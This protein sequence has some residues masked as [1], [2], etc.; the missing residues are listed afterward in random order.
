MERF[1]ADPN[2]I[3]SVNGKIGGQVEQFP[4]GAFYWVLEP[5]LLNE[6]RPSWEFEYR[7]QTSVFDAKVVAHISGRNRNL[8]G[9]EVDGKKPGKMLGS[10]DY[11]GCSVLRNP[12]K[13]TLITL[14]GV[15]S[16]PAA[17]QKRW[18]GIVKENKATFKEVF[19]NQPLNHP[20]LLHTCVQRELMTSYH[21]KSDF[22]DQFDRRMCE[23]IEKDAR[24]S[25]IEKHKH[26]LIETVID[27]MQWELFY[28]LEWSLMNKLNEIRPLMGRPL[29]YSR[30]DNLIWWNKAL[31]WYVN[32]ISAQTLV[33]V[34]ENK[35]L[36]ESKP[37]IFVSTWASSADM[38]SAFSVTGYNVFDEYILHPDSNLIVDE[39]LTTGFNQTPSQT[40][41][42]LVRKTDNNYLTY[43][44]GIENHTLKR[45]SCAGLV[46]QSPVVILEESLGW[47]SIV[48]DGIRFGKRSGE[49]R[50]Q[51]F[52]VL[53]IKDISEMVLSDGPSNLK[54][55]LEEDGFVEDDRAI[56]VLEVNLL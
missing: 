14:R 17:W 23:A 52:P 32:G 45:I 4:S 51:D 9:A 20:D 48:S 35:K 6:K 12:G 16:F 56:I 33:L 26:P 41:D 49:E 13:Y 40:E 42:L 10:G 2:F 8:S 43:R 25:Q 46:R 29:D 44:H 27:D 54:K 50:R 3:G 28:S 30:N 1:A 53:R 11:V 21:V 7:F 34:L 18:N 15:D 19:P 22:F 55:K 31:Q 38:I 24:V 37:S 39:L 5:P 36:L 47:A